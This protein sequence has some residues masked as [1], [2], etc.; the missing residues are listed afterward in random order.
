MIFLQISYLFA[1]CVLTARATVAGYSV[2]EITHIKIKELDIK[3]KIGAGSMGVVYKALYNKHDVAV[4]KLQ[5]A[6]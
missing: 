2:D 3:K 5:S 1:L 6:R 4:K